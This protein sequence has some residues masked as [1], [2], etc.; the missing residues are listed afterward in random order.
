LELRLRTERSEVR[1]L[2][3]APYNKKAP[4][5]FDKAVSKGVEDYASERIK[6]RI[7][8]KIRGFVFNSDIFRTCYDNI[9]LI[10]MRISPKHQ[11]LYLPPWIFEGAFLLSVV[12]KGVVRRTVRKNRQERFLTSAPSA[13]DPQGEGRKARVILPVKTS[14]SI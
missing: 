6:P 8:N 4:S 5:I 11:H 12:L 1:I 14:H 9:P 3:G 2:P 7:F 10:F 13:D